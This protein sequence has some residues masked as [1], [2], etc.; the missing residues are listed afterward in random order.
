MVCSAHEKRAQLLKEE[1]PLGLGILPGC[2]S[3]SLLLVGG[4][5][6]SCVFGFQKHP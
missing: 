1:T 4:M 6:A 5:S 3:G 2:I